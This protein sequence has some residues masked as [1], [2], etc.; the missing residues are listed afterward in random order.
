MGEK[1]QSQVAEVK[2]MV[3][4]FQGWPISEGGVPYRLQVGGATSVVEGEQI[5]TITFSHPNAH[6]LFVEGGP[7]Q[8]P[9]GI[10][11]GPAPPLGRLPKGMHVE[12]S[13]VGALE[14]R[15]AGGGLTTSSGDA[16]IECAKAW[17]QGQFPTWLHLKWADYGF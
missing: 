4:P 14:A 15:G 13:A 11:L 17:Y 2:A 16:C 1:L 8:L 10:E 5:T 6:A 9:E 3:K 7:L 12:R